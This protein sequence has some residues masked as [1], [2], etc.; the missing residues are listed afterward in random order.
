MMLG[1]EAKA[2]DF[3]RRNIGKYERC[4]VQDYDDNKES[5]LVLFESNKVKK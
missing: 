2:I 5:Y 3:D 4:F 1:I